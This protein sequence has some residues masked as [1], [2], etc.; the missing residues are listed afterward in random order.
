MTVN[1]TLADMVFQIPIVELP[2]PV[3]WVK[4]CSIYL[5]KVVGLVNVYLTWIHGL[6]DFY[7]STLLRLLA[8]IFHLFHRSSYAQSYWHCCF[9]GL[10]GTASVPVIRLTLSLLLAL[11][12]WNFFHFSRHRGYQL[13]GYPYRT[14]FDRC[15]GSSSVDFPSG[16]FRV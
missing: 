6:H 13:G 9:I 4:G 12:E 8:F 11:F 7:Q 1:H 3:V 5:V 2:A 15:Q 10:I 14:D 16:H